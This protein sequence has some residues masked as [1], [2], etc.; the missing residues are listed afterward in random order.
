MDFSALAAR[1]FF[2]NCAVSITIDGEMHISR[3]LIPEKNDI[4]LERDFTPAGSIL[5]FIGSQSEFYEF[6]QQSSSSNASMIKKSAAIGY[7]LCNKLLRDSQRRYGFICV[8]EEKG[9]YC[10]GKSLF[11]HAV[12][13]L[14][15]TAW[16]NHFIKGD[17]FALDSVTLSTQL[18]VVDGFSSKQSVQPFFNLITGCWKVNRKG[19]PTMVITGLSAPHVLIVSDS[20]VQELRRDGSF[21]RRFAVLDFSSY[22][23]ADHTP[24]DQFGHIM[25]DDW[26]QEQWHMFDN[27]M[28]YCIQEY[29]SC[30]R[31]GADIFRYYE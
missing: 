18:F 30:Y 12:A 24:F 6:L 9:S 26:E 23:N 10:N 2:K 28:F 14:C 17:E 11:A 29:L 19:E 1:F 22:W 7:I 15:N 27:Y 21:R 20:S 16:T 25:F 4:V 31:K 8:N 13:N 5:E 3:S